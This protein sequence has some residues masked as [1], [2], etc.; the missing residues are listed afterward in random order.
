MAARDQNQNKGQ[1][2]NVGDIPSWQDPPEVPAAQVSQN[3]QFADLHNRLQAMMKYINSLTRDVT[4]FHNLAAARHETILE[5]LKKL[6]SSTG[7]MSNIPASLQ[8]LD[9]ME[10]KLDDVT[11]DVKQT[12]SDLHNALDQHVA[13]LK[14]EVRSTHSTLLGTVSGLGLGAGKFLLIVVGSQAVTVG[15]YLL[16]KR[17][18]NGGMKKYL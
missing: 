4:H 13:G 6:E 16:Y 15:A 9:N 14:S 10:R 5:L 12:K 7:A 1:S 2:A 8:K 3:E 18:K 17:R 11:R